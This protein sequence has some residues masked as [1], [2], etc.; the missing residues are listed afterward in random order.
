M[1]DFSATS[2]FFGKDPF[3]WWIGQVTDPKKGN[4]KQ[5]KERYRTETG[6]EIYSHR[7]RVRIIGYHD[8][9]DDLPDNQ[10]PMAH[11][12]V[13]PNQGVNAGQGETFNYH[14]GEVVLGFFLDGAD[15]QQPVVFGSLFKQQD[16]KDTLTTSQ[17]SSKKPVCFQPWTPPDQ[18]QAM[19]K[20]IITQA[21]Q[22][23]AN[24]F[25]A[26]NTA[27]Q[28]TIAS[29]QTQIDTDVEKTDPTPCED[30]EIERI[31]NFV[32]EFIARMNSYQQILDVYVNPI[33]GKI[34]N[35]GEDIKTTAG[36][37]HDTMTRLIRRA[38]TWLVKELMKK[39]NDFL[40]G[41]IP[42]P[43]KKL[44]GKAVKNIV[45]LIICLFEKIIKQLYNYLKD[46]LENMINAITDVPLCA[47]ENFL[48]DMFGQL[49]SVIDNSIG[50]ILDQVNNIV[51]GALGQI[52]GLISKAIGFSNMFLS[53]LN[54]DE[55]A[56]PPPR[57]WSTRYGPTNT[58]ID[59]FNKSLA[60]ASLSQLIRPTLD[61]VDKMIAA[62]ATAPDCN[63]NVFRCGP[64]RV[65]FV[66]GGG[67]LADGNAII[68]A[69]G[70][71]IGVSV[72]NS[73]YGFTSPP[74]LTLY[75]N[76]RNGYGGGGYAVLGPVSNSGQ[77]DD[78]GNPIYVPNPNGQETGVIGVVIQD[79][80]S[81]YLPN[82]TETSVDENGNTVVKEVIPD[83][84]TNSDGSTSY[85]TEIV[86]VII[87][88]TGF[89]YQD[90]TTVTVLSCD[91][92]TPDT[93]GSNIEV[94]VVNGFIVKAK[95][96]NGGA[97]FTC[98]PK[99]QINSDVGVGAKLLPVL[100]FTKIE[101]AKQF[102]ATSQ[103]AV[104]TVIDCVQK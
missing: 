59:N 53:L 71:L 72:L 76:C 25:S 7:C 93:S 4:W 32:R 31:R 10:L 52:S 29:Q 8:C 23:G 102:V 50:P 34:V 95:V 100:K 69:V 82:T 15:A 99:L 64:P 44:S 57:N 26:N 61:S 30:T 18:K 22:A 54:C 9:V 11:V 45:D 24:T 75:D 43:L 39:L 63:T 89:G 46:S 67:S 65:D 21:T 85:V 14:G 27:R 19:G 42:A 98:L 88:D 84:N 20:H 94:T 13:P 78:N 51:G 96:L 16:I 17:Y 40:V 103:T 62:D 1:E 79:P 90:D 97:G 2:N 56:C 5:T 83:S 73:G 48:S 12:L 91:G 104:V 49:Y 86:D 33:F 6:E 3:V 47:I 87:D 74:L 68:N 60:K 70:Q 35:I 38:R 101:D 92:E 41:L 81:N 77:T 28:K 36:L 80:G 58:Q 66:G 37:I 55:M